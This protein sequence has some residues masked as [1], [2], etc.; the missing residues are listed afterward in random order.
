MTTKLEK[1]LKRELTIAGDPYVLT[2]APEGLSLVPKGK[3]KGYRLAWDAFVN[4]E[5][6]LAT[7]LNASLIAGR[8]T[9]PSRSRASP[10]RRSAAG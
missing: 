3:R 2:I 1:P 5:A 10:A 6:A 9:R 4:G 8:P 7:A